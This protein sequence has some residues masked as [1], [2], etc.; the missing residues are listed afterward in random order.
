MVLIRVTKNYKT[1]ETI[2]TL[3]SGLV[4]SVLLKYTSM[5]LTANRLRPTDDGFVSITVE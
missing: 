5:M 4:L 1:N 2:N 3:C